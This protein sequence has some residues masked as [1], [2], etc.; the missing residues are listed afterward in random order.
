MPGPGGA[1]GGIKEC[2]LPEVRP[3]ARSTLPDKAPNA[4]GGGGGGGGG[5]G[6]ASPITPFAT[7]EDGGEAAVPDR[8]MSLPSESAALNK[9]SANKCYKIKR[10]THGSRWRISSG[11]AD[12]ESA[13]EDALVL[14]F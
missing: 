14:P 4:G 5:A 2:S 8:T 12:L 1:G 11:Y 6:G 7:K 13:A 9:D 10:S 3:L